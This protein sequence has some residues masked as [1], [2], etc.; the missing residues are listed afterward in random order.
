M[1][2]VELLAGQNKTVHQSMIPL[3]NALICG[4]F[5]GFCVSITTHIIGWW[6]GAVLDALLT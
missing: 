3:G 2:A 6:I 1:F 4:F 5:H